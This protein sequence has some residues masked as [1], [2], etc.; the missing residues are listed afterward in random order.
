[1][2]N[3]V[4]IEIQIDTDLKESAEKILA[5]QGYTL[6]EAI[7]LFIKE[8]VRLGKLPFEITDEMITKTSCPEVLR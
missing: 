6:E 5:A 1:M 8:T 4:L 3:T 7:I 2:T